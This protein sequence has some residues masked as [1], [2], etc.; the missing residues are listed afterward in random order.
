MEKVLVTGGS[1]F[2]G[3]HLIKRLEQE[4]ISGVNY[5]IQAVKSSHKFR[6]MQGD[7]MDYDKL[8]FAMRNHDTVCHLAAMVGVVDCIR[9]ESEVLKIDYESIYNIIKACEKNHVKRILFA[10]SSEVYGDGDYLTEES[11]LH[12]KSPYGKAKMYAEEAL[13]DY[14]IH[15]NIQV[16]VI[17]YCNIFGPGQRISFV[18]PIFI[19]DLLTNTPLPIC[20][21]GK[22][23][24]TYTYIDDAIN[25][26]IS[27]LNRKSED[28]ELYNIC[29]E[30][31]YTVLEVAKKLIGIH[32]SGSYYFLPYER[33]SR[34]SEYE[35]VVR[36]PS[37]EKIKQEFKFLPM[38][39]FDQG[40]IGT[41]NFYNKTLK[42]T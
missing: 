36:K 38:V 32:K 39:S 17:R 34:K 5:D 15:S 24:R 7:I 16:S 42:N 6:M 2:I 33:L 1:G 3:S 12:P 14:A 20:A 10:S 31:P 29:G 23:V 26:T 41:Y 30:V 13:R 8:C 11:E 22:Q 27:I 4:G 25:G 28:F 9:L 19:N 40:L 35:I 21:D 18:I 37:N